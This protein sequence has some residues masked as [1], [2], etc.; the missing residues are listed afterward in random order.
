MVDFRSGVGASGADR[1]SGRTGK[2]GGTSALTRHCDTNG[3][4]SRMVKVVKIHGTD[5]AVAIT[6]QVGSIITVRDGQQVAVGDVLARIPQESAKT[7]DIT[8]GTRL[9]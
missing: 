4:G 3:R 2:T 9:K 6:F 7:R 1:L 5:H 8:G